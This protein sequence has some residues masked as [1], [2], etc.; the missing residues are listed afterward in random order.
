M[1]ILLTGHKG[2]VG[3]HFLQHF[4]KNNSHEVFGIDIKDGYDC[5]DFFKLDDKKSGYWDLVIHL[6]AI[7][8]GRQTIEGDPIAVATDLSIDAEMFNWVVRKKPRKVIYFSSS[9]A[10]PVS[11]QTKKN[12][13][14]KLQE[15]DIDFTQLQKPDFTYGWAKL[16]G[17]FLADYAVKNYG[18]NVTVLRPFSGYGEDQDL[19]YP[20][21]SFIRRAKEKQNPFYIWGDGTQVRDFIHIQDIV[22]A[23]MEIVKQEVSGTINLGNGRPTSF[24]ELAQLVANQVGY[25]PQFEHDQSKPVGVHYRVADTSQMLR[26]YQPKISLEEGIT[27][28]LAFSTIT[29]RKK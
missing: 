26:L 16:T 12:N 21:P 2:F 8:G 5:R 14:R 19:S 3:K 25:D 18:A 23:T 17:E 13:G 4:E 15:S 27:R 20:F 9:A 7:V 28:A 11:L 6:A 24:N 22:E 29:K 10:Y 1:N